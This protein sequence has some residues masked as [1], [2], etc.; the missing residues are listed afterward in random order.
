MDN[1]I[2]IIIGIILSVFI[3]PSLIIYNGIIN[4]THEIMSSELEITQNSLSSDLTMTSLSLLGVTIIVIGI[5]IVLSQFVL[6]E[7]KPKV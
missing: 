7:D 6:D 4:Q 5:M 3:G 1:K 2:K